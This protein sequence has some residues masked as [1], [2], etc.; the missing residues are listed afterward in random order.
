MTR[1]VVGMDTKTRSFH[2]V[3]NMSLP[4][5]YQVYGLASSP[6]KVDV[7]IARVELFRSA[8]HLFAGLHPGTY[9]F[10]EEPLALSKN[11]QTTRLLCLAAGAIWSAF[12]QSNADATWVWTNPATW[13][14]DVLGRGA[15]PRGEKHKPWIEDTLLGRRDFL[16][17][18]DRL[19]ARP[20]FAASPDFYDA[21]CLMRHGAG[22][23]DSL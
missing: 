14:K 8:R 22:V 9:V 21:W 16:E 17:W 18:A 12:I 2:W 4:G 5:T 19:N 13:K 1:L 15:P 6:P 23:V 20:T 7:E 10:C 3:S 11:P